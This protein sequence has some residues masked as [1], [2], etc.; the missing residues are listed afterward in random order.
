MARDNTSPDYM[1]LAVQRKG[2]LDR[3]AERVNNRRNGPTKGGECD[4]RRVDDQGLGEE[5][6]MDEM[7]DLTQ[8]DVEMLAMNNHVSYIW[9]SHTGLPVYIVWIQ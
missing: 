3:G 1:Q 6:R 5:R 4:Y 7:K 2:S 8:P 9:V